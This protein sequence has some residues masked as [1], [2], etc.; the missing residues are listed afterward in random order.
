MVMLMVTPPGHEIKNKSGVTSSK[1]GPK[2]VC[3]EE[4]KD[5]GKGVY[6]SVS[7]PS[8]FLG[9]APFK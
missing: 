7:S 5:K 2:R 3:E 9:F 4:Y 8:H 1:E 6:K